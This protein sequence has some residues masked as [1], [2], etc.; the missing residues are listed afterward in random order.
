MNTVFIILLVLAA[1]IVL[2]LIAGLFVRREYSIQR[3][4]IVRRS[5]EDVFDYVRHLKNQ[6]QFSKWVMTDPQKKTEFR[7]KDGTVGFVYAWNGNKQAG[8]GEQE[9][10]GIKEGERVDI[11]VRFIRPFK[12]VARTPF[13]IQRIHQNETRVVWGMEGTSSYPLNLM[14]AMMA[15]VLAKDLD[16][17][18]HTLK[19]NMEK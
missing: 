7:G 15:G 11:E 1:I 6:D 19:N 2:I 9:I 8:E 13:Q 17:S 16:I 18:L 14:Y 4:V 12:S 5:A 10:I 3:E